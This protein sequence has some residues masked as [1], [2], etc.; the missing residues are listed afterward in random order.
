MEKN[1]F[2]VN[3]KSENSEILAYK[4]GLMLNELELR[5]KKNKLSINATYN[6]AIDKPTKRPLNKEEIEAKI[7]KW[8]NNKNLKVSKCLDIMKDHNWHLNIQEWD[9]LMKDLIP[10]KDTKLF[11]M[12]LT[13]KPYERIWINSKGVQKK[14]SDYGDILVIES[15]NIRLNNKYE[16][17][18]KMCW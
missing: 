6:H 16:K 4:I 12:N 9:T 10:I 8:S 1:A 11:L 18:I 5:T 2:F 17:E 7:K 3:L 15:N 13:K 14:A